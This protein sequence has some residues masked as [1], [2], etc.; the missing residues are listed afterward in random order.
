[1]LR[2]GVFLAAIVVLAGG[3]L[4]VAQSHGPR[5]DYTH[6]H[7]EPQALRSP[8]GIAHRA[9]ALDARGL[10]QLGLLILIATPVARVGMCVAGFWFEKDHL[11]VIVSAI[12]LAILLYSLFFDH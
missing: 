10:I 12:V 9:W 7:G 8:S 1:M 6:F 11:Y 3:V 5:N 2:T 4:Y